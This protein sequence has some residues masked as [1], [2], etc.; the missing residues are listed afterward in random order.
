[1]SLALSIKLT[2]AADLIKRLAAK[3]E[4]VD[5]KLLDAKKKG[6]FLVEN[7]AKHLSRVITG[8]QRASITTNWYGSG[9]NRATINEPV[10]E[11]KATDGVHQPE[12]KIFDVVVGTNVEYAPDNEA[13]IGTRKPFLYPAVAQNEARINEL[14]GAVV[15]EAIEKND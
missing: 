5:Q 6:G 11:S 14:C 1:M 8:R 2:G 13:G 4:T 12:D 15:K 3:I 9:M 10:K 7:T